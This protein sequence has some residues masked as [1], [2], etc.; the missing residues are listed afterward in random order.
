MREY[1]VRGSSHKRVHRDGARGER[2]VR[3]FSLQ[4]DAAVPGDGGRDRAAVLP[5]AR[6][7]RAR[8][9]ARGRCAWTLRPGLD[10]PQSAV[11]Q[12]PCDQ[13]RRDRPDRRFWRRHAYVH[14]GPRAFV[15]AA[16]AHARSGVRAWARAGR[17]DDPPSR[18]RRLASRIE[19][20]R[21]ARHWRG[22]VD[23]LDRNRH[24]D[25]GREQT[26]PFRRR[27]RELGRAALSGSRSRASFGD[28]RAHSQRKA[29]TDW[30]GS[31]SRL[32]RRPRSG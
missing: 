17:R 25:A 3:P 6:E 13:C 18:G 1:D 16:Q 32:S 9:S 23:V 15:R 28:D 5:A 4:R 26:P 29:K 8:L 30:P 20:S 7:P 11:A 10:R 27:S 14:H 22:L 19:P 31:S 24:S 12:R 21:G 2:A